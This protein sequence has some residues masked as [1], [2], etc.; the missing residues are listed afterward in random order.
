MCKISIVTINYNNANGF[1]KTAKSVINQS[2]IDKE[3]IVIDGKST[4]RSIEFIKLFKSK[5]DYWESEVD[6]GIYHAMNKGI[7]RASGEYLLFLN[8]GDWLV[9]DVL[10]GIDWENLSEDI[11][12]FN[13]HRYY[14]PNNI[15]TQIYPEKL[16]LKQFINSNI[17]HQ[18]TFIK[19]SLFNTLGLYNV[20][21]KFHG[22]FDFWL[23]ALIC[24]N[25]TYKYYPANLSYY[26]MN[27]L[28]SRYNHESKQERNE[29]LLKYVPVRILEDYKYWLEKD[30]KYEILSWYYQSKLYPILVLYYKII[31]KISRL[32]YNRK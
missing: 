17:G 27:G 22:D 18:A 11:I 12:Y 32:F 5:I 2:F 28:T 24:N 14:A 19:R 1:K 23:N 15:Q 20:Q 9:E 29:I 6:N 31:K 4:D 16:T 13:M 8:S 25:C 7:N 30:K 21:Y 26:D 3:F 10:C